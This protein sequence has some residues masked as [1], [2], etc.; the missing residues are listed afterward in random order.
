MVIQ[1]GEDPTLFLESL[2]YSSQ[3]N[4]G[5]VNRD[6]L[7]ATAYA[8]VRQPY[9]ARF[10]TVPVPVSATIG[11]Q[12]VSILL[13]ESLQVMLSC[14]LR[15]E[16]PLLTGTATYRKFV[17]AR[18][19]RDVRIL[20][21][22]QQ[23]MQCDYRDVMTDYLCNLE[24]SAYESFCD[25]HLGGRHPTNVART[26]LVPI[27]MW[28]SA[29]FARS[30]TGHLGA[31]PAAGFAN[32]RLEFILDF[33][34]SKQLTVDAS[35][36]PAF[37]S[38][39]MEIHEAL[40]PSAAM[41]AY[42]R[43]NGNYSLISRAMRR[44]G[45]IDNKEY[46]AENAA[47]G[48]IVTF[49]C[50]S[51][52]GSFEEIVILAIKKAGGTLA[53]HDLDQFAFVI[54]TSMALICDS[55]NVRVLDQAKAQLEMFSNGFTNNEDIV[56]PM[57]FC[58]GSHTRAYGSS[59]YCGAFAFDAISNVQVQLTFAEACYVRILGIC[60]ARY[61]ITTTGEVRQSLR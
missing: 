55:R 46:T 42:A 60:K 52:A 26:V 27:P 3:W 12:N 2:P 57:R 21:A 24:R 9:I 49:E 33:A 15:I 31:I 58:L 38:I 35:V 37:T 56:V 51:P 40:L 8:R 41:R 45:T 22:G 13:P 6:N 5:P 4:V 1:G 19:L 32:N 54:P 53:A 20:S 14:Y 16:L 36:V 30:H 23:V 44:L 59:S 28:N 17:G 10:R 29:I 47:A 34:N 39:T 50:A 43:Q 25:T 11:A 18:I 7:A 48:T 61:S